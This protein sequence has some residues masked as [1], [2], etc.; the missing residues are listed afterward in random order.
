MHMKIATIILSFF[1]VF[2]YASLLSAQCLQGDCL[3]G[4][5]IFVYPNGNRFEGIWKGG[6]LQ[7]GLLNYQNGDRY[8]GNFYNNER[9]GLGLYFYQSGNRY[10]G[11]FSNGDKVEGTFH[12]NNGN[13]Y[14]GQFSDNMRNGLGTMYTNDGKTYNGYWRDNKYVDS[15]AADRNISGKTYALIVGVSDYAYIKDLT[16]AH[17]DAARFAEF[18]ASEAGGA[19]PSDRLTVL[20]NHNATAANIKRAMLALFTK[21]TAMD[22]IIFYFSGHGSEGVFCPYDIYSSNGW[23]NAL[24]HSQIKDIFRQSDAGTKLCLADA[25]F[26]GSIRNAQV[27]TDGNT[28]QALQEEPI[29]LD[30]LELQNGHKE[31]RSGESRV[32]VL[33]SSRGGETS[34]EVGSLGQGVF[35][36]FLIQGMKGQADSNYDHN[37]T[38]KELFTYLY[39]RVKMYTHGKQHPNL[40]CNDCLELPM[41]RLR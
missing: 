32:A 12:Y 18:L 41:F 19:L 21:A 7:N 23:V 37:L 36:Y 6:K 22:R 3:N 27:P 14:I 16:F 20:L 39:R 26:S 4:S 15:I 31:L 38:F 9:H 11:V 5:G 28:R 10:E 40:M 8:Q 1:F 29:T 24:G 17:L 34:L 33:M 2:V 35:S 30:T 25:C 13:R